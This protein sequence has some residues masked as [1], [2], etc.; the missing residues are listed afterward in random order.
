MVRGAALIARAKNDPEG[1]GRLPPLSPDTADRV[2]QWLRAAGIE[3][4]A[5]FQ[6]IVGMKTLGPRL[7][8]RVL[9]EVWRR[10][11]R[12]AG[13]PPEKWLRFTS[14]STW[15]GAAQD[16]SEGRLELSQIMQAGAWRDSRQVWRY[17]SRRWPGPAEATTSRAAPRK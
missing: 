14:H 1:E 9:T 17:S 2:Q 13:L 7:R 15:V 3:Q 6:R 5:V 11:G 8:P 16:V 12:R 4:G 10:L